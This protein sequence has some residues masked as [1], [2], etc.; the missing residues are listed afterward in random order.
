MSATMTMSGGSSSTSM[1][2]HAY[3]QRLDEQHRYGGAD[4][5][6]TSGRLQHLS[7]LQL[8]RLRCRGTR[9]R[10][11][12]SMSRRAISF[13]QVALFSIISS[14][15]SCQ[16]LLSQSIQLLLAPGQRGL[17]QGRTPPCGFLGK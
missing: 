9:H 10:L 1:A 11:C 7:L 3:Q 12:V 2:K 5:R 16:L 14:T 6:L 17:S 15:R 13:S 8:W 4:K